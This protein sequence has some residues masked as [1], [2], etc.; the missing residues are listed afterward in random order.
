[1]SKAPANI[2]DKTFSALMSNREFAI[3]FYKTYLPAEILE[4]IDFSTLE[5]FNV[6]GRVIDE[7]NL[8]SAQ[9]DAAHTV[10][11]DGA[12]ML[13]WTHYEHQT[14]PERFMPV[15]VTHYQCGKLL[16]YAKLNKCEKLPPIITIIYHQGTQPYTYSVNL[17][18]L[19]SDP[20][21]AEKYFAKP[22]LVDLPA[23]ADSEVASHPGIGPAEMVL[24]YIR[25]QKFPQKYQG[26][27]QKIA[28]LDDKTR[29]V[30]IQYL[31]QRADIDEKLLL[32]AIIDHLP[33]DKEIAMTVAQQIEQRGAQ[34]EKCEIAKNMLRKG[35]DLDFITDTTGL[36]REI[37]IKLQQEIKH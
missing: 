35:A 11:M 34:H 24:K 27:I 26:I 4:R 20:G 6:S 31:I 30:L 32:E 16:E 21:L 8:Q 33:Q 14:R 7:D 13:L 18:E 12:D 10:K 25:S 5:I 37:V 23:L 17:N 19:F 28:I 29:H 36:D 3:G 9:V 2:H 22:I 15:R 1:M